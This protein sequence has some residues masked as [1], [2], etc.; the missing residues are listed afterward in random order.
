[1]HEV[2]ADAVQAQ[3]AAV[4]GTPACGP[5]TVAPAP[6]VDFVCEDDVRQA[7][8]H[9]ARITI[10]ERTIVTPLARELGEARGV[11]VVV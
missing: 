9:N 7:L 4:L 6:P 11:F 2:P 10:T 8:R 5:G 1:V 3:I